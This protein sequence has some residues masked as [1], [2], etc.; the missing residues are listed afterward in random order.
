VSPCLAVAAP[1]IDERHRR[2]VIGFDR[3]TRVVVPRLPTKST[4][5]AVTCS[6]GFHPG[7]S[8]T[9]VKNGATVAKAALR[10]AVLDSCDVSG[11]K[12]RY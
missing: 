9:S 7:C 1:E 5:T 3:S 12:R 11:R 6:E 2:R 8:T 10:Q 4:A